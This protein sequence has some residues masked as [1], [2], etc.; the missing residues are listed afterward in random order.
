VLVALN[1]PKRTL[2]PPPPP[3]WNC[4]CGLDNDVANDECEGCYQRK[5]EQSEKKSRPQEVRSLAALLDD[6][7]TYLHSVFRLKRTFLEPIRASRAT[8]V[9]SSSSSSSSSRSSSS[10]SSSSSPSSS[11]PSS[12]SCSSSFPSSSSCSGS[13]PSYNRST[14]PASSSPA[15]A[16][17]PDG[18]GL[19]GM[20]VCV[21]VKTVN[22]ILSMFR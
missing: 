2:P 3:R 13:V 21:C 14:F 12:S 20:C 5:P 1:E 7:G 4:N 22:F 10:S 15:S 11:F 8:F 18:L 6:E 9:S 17:P 19:C 16:S